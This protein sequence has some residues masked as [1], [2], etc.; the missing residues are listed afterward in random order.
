MEVLLV[1]P[2]ELTPVEHSP[3]AQVEQVK[4]QQGA[5]L[6]E[7]EDVRFLAGGCG[8]LLPFAELL[9]GCDLVPVARRIFNWSFSEASDMRS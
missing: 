3:A 5:L 7:P 2:E 4:S 9:H 8:H 6:M 1:F